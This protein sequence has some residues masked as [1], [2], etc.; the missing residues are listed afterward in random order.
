MCDTGFLGV[1]MA[2]VR[3]ILWP[4]TLEAKQ[5]NWTPRTDFPHGVSC[6][7]HIDA[8]ES[9]EDGGCYGLV[10]DYWAE[11]FFADLEDRLREL[12]AYPPWEEENPG[13]D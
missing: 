10:V 9:C 4:M 3:P 13:D 2:A 8:D 7:P 1:L 11:H 12:T 6:C 5:T